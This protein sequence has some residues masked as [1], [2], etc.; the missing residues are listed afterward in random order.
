M[1]DQRILPISCYIRTLNEQRRIGDVVRC[2][3]ALCDEVLVVDSGSTDA[4]ID[5]ARAEGARV[6]PQPWLGNGHQKRV[7][8][9]QA[10]HDWVLDLDADEI[11]SPPLCDEIRQVFAGDGPARDVYKL[12]LTIVD[13]VGRIW[14]RSG[15]SYRAK[16][17]DRRKASMPAERAWDQLELSAQHRVQRLRAPL[18]HYAFDDIGQLVRKQEAAMRNRITGMERRPRLDVQFRVIAGFPCYLAKY[19]LARGLWR[20]GV[21]GLCFS[22]AC[23]YSR[24]LRDVKLY[25]RDW[26]HPAGPTAAEDSAGQS[27]ANVSNPAVRKAA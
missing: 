20:V 14:H 22:Y 9:Q 27:A 13:P 16:L 10:R 8:E 4:T 26:L 18:L 21:Y 12:A 7:G 15:V 3:K 25:E 23:A 17:Y 19:F 1:A 24:W 2:A 6:I 11:L 5:I